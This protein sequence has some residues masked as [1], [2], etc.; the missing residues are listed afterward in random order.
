MEEI[1]ETSL[2]LVIKEILK[3]IKKYT[4]WKHLL[5]YNEKYHLS[6]KI[7]KSEDG[8]NVRI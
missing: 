2:L 1:Y 6:V 8:E 5:K 3:N 4:E 7:I